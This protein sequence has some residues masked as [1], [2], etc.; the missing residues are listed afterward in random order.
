[1]F[2]GLPDPDLLALGMDPAPDP[3]KIWRKTLILTALW[4]HSDFLSFKNVVN[5]ASKSNKQKTLKF[6]VVAIFKVTGENSQRCGAGS[7]FVPKCHG[8]ATLF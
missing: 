2:L 3:A 7:R 1:M 5:R 6:F 8:S 4:L